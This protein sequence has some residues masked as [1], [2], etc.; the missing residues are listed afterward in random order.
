MAR[1]DFENIP[2]SYVKTDYPSNSKYK[3]EVKKETIKPV[4]K[5]KVTRRKTPLS[6]KFATT[7]FNEDIDNIGQYVLHDVL[8]PGAKKI[9]YDM[10]VNSLGMSLFGQVLPNNI[11]RHGSNSLITNYSTSSRSSN[12]RYTR[13]IDNHT[14]T[15]HQFDDIII[16]DKWEAES[17]LSKLV[18]I[19]E[20]YGQATV[21]DLY[22]LVDISHNHAD[23]KY[24]WTN[25]S[26]SYVKR[27]AQ[28]YILILPR[29]EVL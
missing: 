11:K 13:S 26:D 1:Q 9:M 17:V 27:D 22:D 29:T 5:S 18:D 23:L 21:A 2:K 3:K 14:R 4:V 19:I 20:E 7:F 16:E 24:G 12:S 28:G 6:K 10:V 15:T 8:I 25:L